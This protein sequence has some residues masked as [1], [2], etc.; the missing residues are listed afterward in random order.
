[1]QMARER[2]SWR[3]KSLTNETKKQVQIFLRVK[4]VADFA[5]HVDATNEQIRTSGQVFTETNGS[6]DVPNSYIPVF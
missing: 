3:F 4:G 6:S 5:H 1:M 2:T